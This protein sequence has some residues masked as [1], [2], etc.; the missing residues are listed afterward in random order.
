MPLFVDNICI[1][2]ISVNS[3]S[4]PHPSIPHLTSHPT[5]IPHLPPQ[6]HL[7]SSPQLP[8]PPT[9][10]RHLN[11]HL[12]SSPQFPP[13]FPTPIPLFNS[14]PRLLPPPTLPSPP[15]FPPPPYLHSST[16]TSIPLSP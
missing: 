5:S 13:P 15:Q 11:S 16:P 2:W 4:H 9:S 12:H 14:P 3:N 8:P 7:H 10:I 1:K 6:P